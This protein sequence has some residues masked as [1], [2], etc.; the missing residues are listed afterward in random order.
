MG[1][2][3]QSGGLFPHLRVVDNIAVTPSLLAWSAAADITTR[4]DELL[5]LRADVNGMDTLNQILPRIEVGPVRTKD[6]TRRKV[7]VS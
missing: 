5:D 7:D 6:R 3:F 4:V 1:Y 2:V